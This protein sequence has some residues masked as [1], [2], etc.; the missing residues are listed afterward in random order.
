MEKVYD[1]ELA[2]GD[3]EVT[4][5]VPGTRLGLVAGSA[6]EIMVDEFT[7]VMLGQ[8]EGMALN[9]VVG[10]GIDSS[11]EVIADE[12]VTVVLNTGSAL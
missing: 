10:D 3:G 5:V 1:D 2:D 4:R 12:F 6:T 7:E 11:V 8:P 9:M